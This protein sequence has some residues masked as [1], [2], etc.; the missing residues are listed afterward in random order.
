MIEAEREASSY[1]AGW[2][3][4]QFKD[5]FGVSPAVVDGE[6]I[7]PHCAT[8]HEKRCVF[9]QFTRLA[10]DRGY[11]PGWASYRFRDIFGSWPRGFVAE[12]R[13]EVGV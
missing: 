9:E 3:Y 5:R 13:Q 11:K 4:Y 7:D 10:R 6:L 8:F 12:V 1:K 2:S